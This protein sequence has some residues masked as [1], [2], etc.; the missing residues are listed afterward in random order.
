MS[1]T[2]ELY[3]FFGWHLPNGKSFAECPGCGERKLYVNR[4]NGQSVCKVGCGYKGNN[5]TFMN[6]IWEES[7]R[8]TSDKEISEL[9]KLKGIP[10]ST[11]KG[12]GVTKFGYDY[13]IPHF[14]A[15]GKLC[16]LRKFVVDAN[17]CY[18]APGCNTMNYLRVAKTKGKYHVF[19]AD[20]DAMAFMWAINKSPEEYKDDGVIALPGIGLSDGWVPQFKG[21][22]V[23]FYFDYDILKGKKPNQFYPGEKGT[24]DALKK[25]EGM[26]ASFQWIN[27][28]KGDRKRPMDIR[29]LMRIHRKQGG[30]SHTTFLKELDRYRESLLA[31]NF[32][33]GSTIQEAKIERFDQLMDHFSQKIDINPT[34]ERCV[35]ATCATVISAKLPGDNIWMFLRGP[36]SSGKTTVLNAFSE[37]PQTV[38]LSTLSKTALV[39]GKQSEE[40]ASTLPRL[41][42]KCLIVKDLTMLLTANRSQQEETFGTL[43]DAY[44]SEISV[45][46]GTGEWK[47]YKQIRFSWVSGV[48]DIINKFNK[49]DVGERFIK[50]D[51]MDDTFDESEM[52]RKGLR[53]LST[54]DYSDHLKAGCLGYINRLWESGFED[55]IR[56]LPEYIEDRLIAFSQVVETLRAKVDRDSE[57][58]LAYRSRRALGSRVAKQLGKLY[59]MLRFIYDVEELDDEMYGQLIN[60]L[61]IDTVTSIQ[62]EICFEVMNRRTGITVK[63]LRNKLQLGQTTIQNHLNNMQELGFMEYESV[64]N[65]SDNKGRNQSLWLPSQEFESLWNESHIVKP[66][67]N[68]PM[69]DRIRRPKKPSNKFLK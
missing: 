38:H 51:I 9:F 42:N 4:D 21:R 67:C 17:T 22:H 23:C 5:Y 60:K 18:N 53:N 45:P 59:Q 58:S 20:F 66:E 26:V 65:N 43:R 11:L 49:S 15:K 46:Y 69:L 34:F 2:T 37:C 61:G 39:S 7:K 19:E 33:I 36:S 6:S 48:T 62:S 50:V 56:D 25:L 8:V 64:S 3:D 54:D 1:V 52:I 55:N 27:W 47:V 44:D 32:N 41:K 30:D 10:S 29:D 57:G 12:C 40:D 16:N 63:D 68:K 31:K 35:A 28:S 14:N 13:L 24:K